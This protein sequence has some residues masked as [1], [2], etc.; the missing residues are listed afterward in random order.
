MLLHDLTIKREHL[1]LRL[2]HPWPDRFCYYELM[3][4]L[5]KTLP[6]HP[7]LWGSLRRNIKLDN[8]PHET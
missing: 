2:L 8:I 4:F 7:P 6:W 1:N 3:F 5:R